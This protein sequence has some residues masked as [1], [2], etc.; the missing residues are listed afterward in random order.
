MNH[1][2]RV[3]TVLF[4]A[5]SLLLGSPL[6]GTAQLTAPAGKI[7]SEDKPF[8]L[9]HRPS[10]PLVAEGASRAWTKEPLLVARLPSLDR[11]FSVA[12]TAGSIAL[13]EEKA[14]NRSASI[15]DLLRWSPDKA[16]LFMTAADQA[17]AGPRF[18]FTKRYR[19]P[20]FP[21]ALPRSSKTLNPAPQYT[22]ADRSPYPVGVFAWPDF[23][24]QP[25]T[26]TTQ[27]QQYGYE[28][29]RLKF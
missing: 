7:L 29:F 8:E 9:A 20:G 21:L 22:R 26:P 1:R 3:L 2:K 18:S 25:Q 16:L 14:E 6:M 12:S 4:G 15:L 23:P 11:A 17:A 24:G 28:F 27:A 19:M 10:G 13:A 5:V